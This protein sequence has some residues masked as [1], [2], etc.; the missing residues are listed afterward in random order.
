MKKDTLSIIVP[1]YNEEDVLPISSEQLLNTLHELI[2]LET[3]NENSK[4]LFVD[5]GSSDKTWEIISN[6]YNS[7]PKN[8][9]GIKLSRNYGHQK[10]LQAGMETVA[11]TADMIVTIDAD[12]Q[13]DLQ[14]IKKMLQK[15]NEGNDIVYGVRENRETD[16]FFKRNTALGFYKMMGKLGVKLVPNHADFRLLSNRAMKAVLLFKEED[17]FLRGIVPLVGYPSTKVFYDRK[18]R[19]AGES[20]YPL[21]KM[22]RFATNG[23]TSFSLIPIKMIR[24]MGFLTLLIGILYIFYT[25][26]QKYIGD[27]VH[28]WS[29]I[30][31]SI[32]ILGGMQLVG[33]SILGEY[34]GRVYSEVKDRPAFIIE[35]KLERD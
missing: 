19:E 14:A 11:D 34:L 9:V 2:E 4:L 16:T 32:W 23:L 8:V 7:Y 30:I 33:M 29:S 10:A 17:P 26:Y 28:G 21:K 1:C 5:D 35:Q 6:L 15:F 18:K 27:S 20:K 24:N 25:F 13:D 22:I 12:L 31:M 3:I